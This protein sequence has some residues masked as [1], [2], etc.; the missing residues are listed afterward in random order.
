VS[1]GQERRREFNLVHT[2]GWVD[3]ARQA[4]D[5]A[6]AFDCVDFVCLLWPWCGWFPIND[7]RVMEDD[8][9]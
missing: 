5:T 7:T 3:R 9:P 6:S 2:R 4:A 1:G 8:V